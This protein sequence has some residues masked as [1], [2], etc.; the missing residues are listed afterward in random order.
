VTAFAF[1]AMFTLI[2]MLLCIVVFVPYL[3]QV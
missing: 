3:L 1:A 2:F